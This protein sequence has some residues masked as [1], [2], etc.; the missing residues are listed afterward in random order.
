MIVGNELERAWK[1]SQP[2]LKC[3]RSIYLGE[4]RKTAKYTYFRRVGVATETRNGHLPNTRHR[5]YCFSQLIQ[6]IRKVV[7]K[8]FNRPNEVQIFLRKLCV[9]NIRIPGT[10]IFIVPK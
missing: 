10:K 6:S 9:E 7:S 3:N 4:L 8:C 1:W 2:N 5:R